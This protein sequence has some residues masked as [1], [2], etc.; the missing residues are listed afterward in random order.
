MS[1]PDSPSSALDQIRERHVE[2]VKLAPGFGADPGD[3]ERLIK[4]V[5]AVLDLHRPQESVVRNICAA[6]ANPKLRKSA[7]LAVFRAEVDACPDCRKEDVQVCAHC[8]CPND[9]WP[10]P[11]YRAI[12]D[13]L[14]GKEGS[15]EQ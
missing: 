5:E 9:T 10:C 6:H 13:A 2:R 11:T 7:T 12:T 4:A 1:T 3:F 15:D 14:T 8:D